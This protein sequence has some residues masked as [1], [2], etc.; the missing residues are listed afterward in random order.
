M[1]NFIF[2]GTPSLAQPKTLEAVI[3]TVNK[4]ASLHDQAEISMEVNPTS[5]KICKLR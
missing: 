3:D 5:S 1:I 4:N 2:A